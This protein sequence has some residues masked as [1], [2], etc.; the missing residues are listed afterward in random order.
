MIAAI[1][2]LIGGGLLVWSL[3]RQPAVT[4]DAAALIADSDAAMRGGQVSRAR[5]LAKQAVAA[6]P[7]LAAAHLA[8]A[9]GA[10]AEGD[11][12]T[13]EGEI[14]RAID[15][16]APR[17]A[18]R[19]M[20]AHAKLLQNDAAGALA[21][22]RSV[23]AT[24]R[25]YGRRIEARALAATGDV[26]AAQALWTRLLGEMPDDPAL[27]TD[28][29]R[30]NLAQGDV[31]NA[32]AAADRALAL[33]P[34]SLDAL[35]LRAR[36]A[37]V[38]IDPAAA[39]AWQR[40]ALARDP[41]SY[42][43]LIDH[44]ATLGDLGQGSAMLAATRRALAVRPG[45]PQAFYLL[46]TLAART[47]KLD[48]A[49]DLFDRVSGGFAQT[50]GALLLGATLDIDGGDH[51]QAVA[52]LRNLVGL[53]PMNVRARQLLAVALLRLDSV[54]EALTVLRPIALRSDAD[55]YTLTLA[56]RAF[57]RQGNRVEAARLLDRAATLA[58]GPAGQ[59]AAEDSV[60]V[61]ASFA[62][63]G[64]IP[65]TV[66]LIRA[67]LDDGQGGAAV[68]AAARLTQA[69]PTL[70]A[71]WLA[72]GDT[73]GLTGRPADA[74][75]AY[76][77]AGTLAFDAP[78][79]LRIAPLIGATGPLQRYR[80]GNPADPTGLR[81]AAL[82]AVDAAAA[83][84][85]LQRLRATTRNGDAMVLAALALTSEGQPAV[86][87]GAAAYRLA[88]SSA[89]ACD[90]YGWALL[91]AGDRDGASQVL[92]KAVLLAPDN[93]QIRAHLSQLGG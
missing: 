19:A 4:R 58:S 43:A 89:L 49:R 81:L 7:T 72:Y 38:Q 29:A 83:R 57:E 13:A 1:A 34:A 40:R 9:R 90:A 15:A 64:D 76:R 22:A 26:A 41:T 88:P 69:R 16:G 61:A 33:D 2:L 35:L 68:E 71:A 12:L 59:F 17:A 46:A 24:D 5:S 66:P 44:A 21:I 32:V 78:T 56:A 39:L 65:T 37:R 52:K 8:A 82:R 3:L 14:D 27:L 75:T 85:P 51:E 93:R 60:A 63:P 62:R 92:R 11:G 80:A 20:A 23:P 25:A 31:G 91:R 86:A 67:L 48:I 87:A 6:D 73:L 28:V 74:L 53:Q 54:S 36:V 84:G 77:R 45:D 42:A 30:F 18:T 47:G 79:M 50:P 10:L 55:S 70:P